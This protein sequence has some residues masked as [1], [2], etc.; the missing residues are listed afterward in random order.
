MPMAKYI[1]YQYSLAIICKSY[2]YIVI[3]NST[4]P[5]LPPQVKGKIIKFRV[6]LQQNEN[7]QL[8]SYCCYWDMLQSNSALDLQKR[9]EISKG[10]YQITFQR[11][12]MSLSSRCSSF[13]YSDKSVDQVKKTVSA[14]SWVLAIS[15]T[16]VTEE[17][18]VYI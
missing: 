6:Q 15:I 10:M 7:L 11:Q 17:S 12:T 1:K 16:T 13:K 2:N 9:E 14:R 3:V 8:L 18:V 5:L 4:H